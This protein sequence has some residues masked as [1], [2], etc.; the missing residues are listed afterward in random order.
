MSAA[1]PVSPAK[2]ADIRRGRLFRR[3]FLFIMAL[4]CG[5]LLASGGIS[6]YASYQENRA[7]LARLQKEKAVSAAARIEQGAAS[8][9]LTHR[10]QRRLHREQHAIQHAENKAKAD[11]V[12]TTG[13]RAKLHHMQNQAHRD[14]RHQKH[15]RQRA[16][17]APQ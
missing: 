13:E 2:P 1:V 12:V 14:I 5:A 15:D 3:Y 10:E 16:A 7:G 6:L 4:V 8:G 9:A 11:G 17:S